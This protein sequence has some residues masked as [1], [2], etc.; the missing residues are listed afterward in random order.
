M[1]QFDVMGDFHRGKIEGTIVDT[2]KTDG[3]SMSATNARIPRAKSGHKVLV[4]E[5][6]EPQNGDKV[7]VQITNIEAKMHSSTRPLALL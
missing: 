2:V 3:L 1:Q 5:T 7:R 6:E 4:E